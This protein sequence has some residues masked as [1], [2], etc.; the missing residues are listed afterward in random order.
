MPKTT[1]DKHR[2]EWDGVSPHSSLTCGQSRRGGLVT[3][4]SERLP[5]FLGRVV[6]A[7]VQGSPK[8]G[9]A[10]GS[11]EVTS[12]RL[13][14]VPPERREAQLNYARSSQNPQFGIM[15]CRHLSRSVGGVE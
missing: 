1:F 6:V 12:T 11:L 9:D 14:S 7:H 13:C 2:L 3:S 8:G 10:L 4:H 5:S 15:T